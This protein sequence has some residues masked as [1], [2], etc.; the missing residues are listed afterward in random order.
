MPIEEGIGFELTA[1]DYAVMCRALILTIEDARRMGNNVDAAMDRFAKLNE[2][3]IMLVLDEIYKRALC[4]DED[5]LHALCSRVLQAEQ[6][7]DK[8]LALYRKDRIPKLRKN[9]K[10]AELA[11]LMEGDIPNTR[12]TCKDLKDTLV[13]QIFEA[14]KE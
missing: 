2:A 13:V 8:E 9:R 14:E 7:L 4:G 6:D 1:D 11:L 5:S 3:R 10:A 12:R